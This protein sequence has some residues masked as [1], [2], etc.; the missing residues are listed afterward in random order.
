MPTVVAVEG[1]VVVTLR[2]SEAFTATGLII[3]EQH[4]KPSTEAIVVASSTDEVG[5]G[6]IVLLS[7]EYAGA[8]FKL[9]GV[10]YVTVV[11]E[12]ILGILEES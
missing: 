5:I 9:D 10:E 8:S 1:K 12:E 11:L 2:E 6:D 7:G 4:R 3:P